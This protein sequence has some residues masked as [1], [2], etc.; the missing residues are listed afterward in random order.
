MLRND[1]FDSITRR[2]KLCMK[3]GGR[4]RRKVILRLEMYDKLVYQHVEN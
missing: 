2:S 3:M 1:N 4:K